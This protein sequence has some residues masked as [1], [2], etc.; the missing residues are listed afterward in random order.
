MGRVLCTELA[1]KTLCLV[2]V[3]KIGKA[4]ARMAKGFGM[5]VIGVRKRTGAGDVSSSGIE[6]IYTVDRLNDA[7]A[8]SDFVI[9]AIPLNDETF[10][11][12][13]DAQF[14]AMKPTAALVNVSR[15]PNVDRNALDNALAE[16]R[17]ASFGA[18]VYWK[19]PADPADPLLQD[20][21]V[22]ITPH[23]GAESGEAIDRMSMAARENIDRFVKGEP[24][25]NV[26]NM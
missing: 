8:V 9:L 25:R 21:R 20:P 18:D 15:G 10:N 16:H 4:L 23:I 5:K 17:I 6:S 3:G 26:V 2:G 1:G 22:F 24:L 13:G 14:R 7:L 11:L 19:E 12:I